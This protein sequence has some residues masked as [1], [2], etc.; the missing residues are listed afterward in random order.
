MTDGTIKK[1]IINTETKGRAELHF[2]AFCV[3]IFRKEGLIIFDRN[4][5][6]RVE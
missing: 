4:I 1:I 5:E 2:A 3:T 6:E